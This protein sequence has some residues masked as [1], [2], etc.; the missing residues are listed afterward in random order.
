MAQALAARLPGKVRMRLLEGAGH[1]TTLSHLNLCETQRP[2][3]KMRGFGAL[4][5]AAP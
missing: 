3:D 1:Y 4:R 5:V 2:L